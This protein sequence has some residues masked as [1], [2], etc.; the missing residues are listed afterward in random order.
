MKKGIKR[1][2][3]VLLV[4]C[5]LITSIPAF[6][7]G[8]VWT[9]ISE[10][11]SITLDSY[12][13]RPNGANSGMRMY[14]IT[15]QTGSII[16]CSSW[17]GASFVWNGMARNGSGANY[18]WAQ[19]EIKSFDVAPVYIGHYDGVIAGSAATTAAGPAGALMN[20]V[21]QFMNGAIESFDHFT[22][23]EPE[24]EGP[25]E[26]DG[27]G[28]HD[29]SLDHYT[30]HGNTWENDETEILSTQLFW[31]GMS[32]SGIDPGYGS[33]DLWQIMVPL[34]NKGQEWFDI[35]VDKILGFFPEASAAKFAI[36][37]LLGNDGRVD[38][39]CLDENGEEKHE[40]VQTELNKDEPF[41]VYSRPVKYD[42]PN[43]RYIVGNW[44]SYTSIGDTVVN[45]YNVQ[46]VNNTTYTTNVQYQTQVS[47]DWNPPAN[48]EVVTFTPP[49]PGSAGTTINNVYNYY[50]TYEAPTNNYVENI[51]NNYFSY[52]AA[53]LEPD[54]DVDQILE[55]VTPAN[56]FGFLK[57]LLKNVIKLFKMFAGCLS[58]LPLWAQVV[59]KAVV[60]ILG[61]IVIGIII[62]KGVL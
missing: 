52:P 49:E 38:L 20:N 5:I 31:M 1:I 14:Y 56:F 2:M 23:Y 58:F 33:P 39:Y 7:A 40:V 60:P 50:T 22:P 42:E 28:E 21:I 53:N 46:N 9:S 3:P 6:A 12:S 57:K 41:T 43:N 62:V 37:L 17:G 32:N 47:F 13:Y 27:T 26:F 48:S 44:Q 15:T 45:R 11:R 24:P 61:I 18:L 55:G 25:S 54:P 10:C 59:V 29:D 51:T 35:T 8:N 4:L 19:G 34:K 30:L 36:D 16:F